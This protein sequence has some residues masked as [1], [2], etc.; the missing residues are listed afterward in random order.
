[1]VSADRKILISQTRR[2]AE[3]GRV[4]SCDLDTSL[5]SLG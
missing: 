3:S 4:L 1:M 5:R 2:V